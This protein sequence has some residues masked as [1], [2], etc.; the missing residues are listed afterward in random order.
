MQ[1]EQ[2]LADAERERAVGLAEE[3]AALA[4]KVRTLGKALEAYSCWRNL[5]NSHR[6]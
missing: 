2:G 6:A 4:E 1:Q 5:P 3:K